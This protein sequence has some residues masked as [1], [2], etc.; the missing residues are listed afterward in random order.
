[1]TG[2]RHGKPTVGDVSTV[3]RVPIGVLTTRSGVEV[4]DG[5]DTV[6]GT[7]V[8]DP[9]EVLESRSLQN[10]WIVVICRTMSSGYAFTFVH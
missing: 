2:R 3:V 9:V 7:D 4:E 1:M 8:D 10:A 5:V 6:F